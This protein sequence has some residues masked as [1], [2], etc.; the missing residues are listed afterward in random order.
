VYIA[1]VFACCTFAGRHGAT[2]ASARTKKGVTARNLSVSWDAV[3]FCI[4]LIF[5]EN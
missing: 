5:L 3:S 4:A 1:A 2:V